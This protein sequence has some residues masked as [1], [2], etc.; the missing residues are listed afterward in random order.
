MQAYKNVIPWNADCSASMSC[1][2]SEV[3]LTLTFSI[4]FT[5]RGAACRA[6]AQKATGN[7]GRTER[8]QKEENVGGFRRWTLKKV[9]AR[10][11]YHSRC[12]PWP[13]LSSLVRPCTKTIIMEAVETSIRPTISDVAGHMHTKP[14]RKCWRNHP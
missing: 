10:V 7:A 13:P 9:G 8:R 11:V 6:H 2:L 4:A 1:L 12:C 3:Y 5:C 14:R